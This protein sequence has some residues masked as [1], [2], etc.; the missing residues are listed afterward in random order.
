MNKRA[1]LL[2]NVV[3]CIGFASVLVVLALQESF[4]HGPTTPQPETGQIVAFMNHSDTHYITIAR[5][6]T[7]L[8]LVTCLLIAW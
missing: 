7:M 5:G 8:A 3:F 4:I 6:C 2:L 1:K